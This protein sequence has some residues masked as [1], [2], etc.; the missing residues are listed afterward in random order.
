MTSFCW[1][2][3]V[4]PRWLRRL[5]VAVAASRPESSGSGHGPATATCTA[6]DA[7]EQQEGPD[8]ETVWQ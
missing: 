4:T 8:E 3:S 5:L 7:V 6:G 2:A 1:P